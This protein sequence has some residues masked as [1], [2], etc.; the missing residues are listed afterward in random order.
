MTD[1]IKAAPA[2][3]TTATTVKPNHEFFKKAK[4]EKEEILKSG[5]STSKRMMEIFF[6][7]LYYLILLP[8]NL[9][10]SVKL[11]Y[12]SEVNIIQLGYQVIIG[13]FLGM[14]T[15]DF[16]SGIVHWIAD[17]WGTLDAPLVGQTFIRSFREHHI[18]PSAMCKHDFIETNGD[19]ALVSCM[20]GAI[21]LI[22]YSNDLFFT[23]Y[24]TF[25]ALM[26]AFT[27]QIHKWSHQYQ[28]PTIVKILQSSGILLSR[29]SHNY[30][31]K[32]PFDTYYC[33]T[34]GWLNY[35]LH[36]INFWRSMEFIVTKLTGYLPRS[37]DLK[38]TDHLNYLKEENEEKEE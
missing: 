14:L 12:I 6:I 22:S 35:P 8:L 29:S 33:I 36:S 9:Y 37:D 17:T 27:N 3:N 7:T 20:L 38:W 18:A 26:I 5:Y 15:A 2:D 11:A 1:Q 13:I 23:L 19:N 16:I 28:V 25:L 24:Y 30:H 21:P 10:Q 34:T 4:Q 31:H 32:S